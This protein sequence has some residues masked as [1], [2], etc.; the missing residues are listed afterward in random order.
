M[1][2]K[3]RRG[4]RSPRGEDRYLFLEALLSAR[5]CFYLSYIGQSVRDNSPLP[6]SVL[7]DELLDM[8]ELGWTAEDGGALRSRLVTQ[9]RLQP[10]SQAYFQQAA[11]EESVRLFSYAEHLCGASAVSGRG[12]QEPQSFVPEPLPEPSAEWRDVSLEQLS[13]FWAHPCEYLLKQRLGVSFDH[14]D[15]LLDTREPFALDGLSRWA[16]GQDLLAAARHGET[17]LLELG[18]ATGYLPHGE[19]GEVLLRREAGKAQRFASSLA[20]FLP[21]ELLAPQP[22]RLALGEFRLSGALNHLSPQG[23]YSYRYGA[24]RTKFLLDWWLNH[25]A[26]CV[27]QPQGVAPVS[28]WWSEEG[29]LKL[30]PVAKAEALLVDLL[31]G[32][33]EG[34][35]RPLPFF[36]R[37]SF[38]LFLALRAEKT[39]LLKAAAKPWFGNHNQAGE[40]EEAY[41]RLAFLDRDPIDE[42]FEQWG[43]RVFAPLVAALEEVNDV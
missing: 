37:S 21:S 10:F 32:Y 11:Q 5:R 19:A 23:R 26:L 4:D 31:T 16:L 22:F 34:L 28:Y 14:K 38:E 15:G 1:A 43:R 20:R 42:A 30:R 17:D 36:P 39:D 2:Q 29:G 8:I 24:L 9:H 13:R 35:Q 7:V 6:P 27:V 18:R 40:C 3:P 25:L 41:C 12:T 33:W